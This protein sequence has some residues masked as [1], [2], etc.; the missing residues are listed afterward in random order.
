MIFELCHRPNLITNISDASTQS[1]RKTMVGNL[2]A[3]TFV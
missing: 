3:D 1:K 2:E